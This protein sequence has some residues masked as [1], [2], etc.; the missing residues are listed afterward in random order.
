MR[1]LIVL[2]AFV[3]AIVAAFAFFRASTEISGFDGSARVG[4]L[5]RANVVDYDRAETFKPQWADGS[6]HV[7][8]A[9]F[10]SASY[11]SSLLFVSVVAAS[12]SAVNMA[13]LFYSAANKT[14][15]RRN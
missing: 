14:D 5:G 15:D 13:F 1:T 2:N 4:E 9:R 10:I 7:H 11:L 8:I 6:V 3:L 12:V